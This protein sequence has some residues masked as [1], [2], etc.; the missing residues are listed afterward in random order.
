MN[1]FVVVHVKEILKNKIEE[2]KDE[3]WK[4]LDKDY[5]K[6]RMMTRTLFIVCVDKKNEYFKEFVN[7]WVIHTYYDSFIGTGILLKEKEIFV[8][9]QKD[10][11]GCLES[12]AMA[13]YFIEFINLQKSDKLE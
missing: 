6:L 12:Q 8:L 1:F 3:Y 10:G 7:N 13:R 11:P 5:A 9:N 4:Y 2:I